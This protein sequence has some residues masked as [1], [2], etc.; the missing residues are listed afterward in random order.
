MIKL[1]FAAATLL[2]A[3]PSLFVSPAPEV[4]VTDQTDLAL[5]TPVPTQGLVVGTNTTPP[6]PTPPTTL[7]F[8]LDMDSVCG[9]VGD[10]Q[11]EI[12]VATGDL[13]IVSGT[14]PLGTPLSWRDAI[15]VYPGGAY[16]H[17]VFMVSFG[18]WPSQFHLFEIRWWPG[19]MDGGW[20]TLP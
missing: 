20:R 4:E 13:T 10:L 19:G 5:S 18:P 15:R 16:G 12:D 9:V 1:T 6:S 8:D 7:S 14:T 3:I 2:A 11:I 17:G